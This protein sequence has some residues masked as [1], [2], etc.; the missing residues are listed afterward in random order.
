[1]DRTSAR[2]RRATQPGRHRAGQAQKARERVGYHDDAGVKSL[3]RRV[4][5]GAHRR[6]GPRSAALAR[7]Q[8]S[9]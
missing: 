9:G 5:R 3:V 1:M 4:A 7:C 6:R 2:V 8:A